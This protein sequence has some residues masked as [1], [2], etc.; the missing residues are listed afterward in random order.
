MLKFAISQF[1]LC[2]FFVVISLFCFT[3]VANDSDHILANNDKVENS[4]NS[5]NDSH[6]LLVFLENDYLNI[7]EKDANKKIFPASLVKI[8]TAYLTFEAIENK[9]LSLDQILTVS[10]RGNSISYINKVTTLHLKIGDNITVKDALYGMIIKSFNGAAV[11]LSEAVASS[12]WEF[13]KMMSNKSMELGMY[14][15][16]FRNASGLHDYDQYTTAYDLKK[17]IISIK[18][19]FPDYYKIFGI[20]EIEIFDKKFKS[21]NNVLLT[22]PGAEGMKTGFTSIS[23]FNLISAAVKNNKRVFSI[24]LSCESSDMRNKFTKDLL[25]DAF[26]KIESRKYK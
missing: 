22:Y 9:Q 25:D 12:E 18:N 10:A 23:G 19:D 3:V 1:S 14:N 17:L 15:T 11:T 24:L 20:K 5:C 13:A 16:N 26:V 6:T 4:I 2:V 8:M 21:H 7:R